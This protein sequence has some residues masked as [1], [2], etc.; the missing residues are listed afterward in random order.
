V[1]GIALTVGSVIFA[2]PFTQAGGLDPH[3]GIV[4]G[5]ERRRSIE[6]FQSDVVA[7]QPLAASGESF[8]DE[9]F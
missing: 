3:K 4:R 2:K 8:V 6:D 7:L 9:V 5:I 1:N